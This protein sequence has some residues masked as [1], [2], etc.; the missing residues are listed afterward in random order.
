GHTL[1]DASPM[2]L[3][4]TIP[5][6]LL[7]GGATWA[8]LTDLTSKLAIEQDKFVYSSALGGRIILF[9][10]VKVY[11][12]YSPGRGNQAR[13][14]IEIH[15]NPVTGK[16]ISLHSDV[17]DFETLR[18]W[19]VANFPNAERLMA[20]EERRRMMGNPALGATV[21]ERKRFLG[22]ARRVCLLVN[23]FGL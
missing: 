6:L 15:P 16:I 8:L 19:V 3:I 7:F 21:E 1:V 17:N 14:I 10:D 9:T 4:I 13:K 23:G 12:L 11:R 2:L 22:R 20:A 18:D 5:A